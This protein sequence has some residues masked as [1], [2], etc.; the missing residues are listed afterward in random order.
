MENAHPAPEAPAELAHELRRQRHFGNQHQR[1]PSRFASGGRASQID[2]G[3][4]ARGDAVEEQRRESSGARGL[5]HR[6]HRRALLRGERETVRERSG[7]HT[8]LDRGAPAAAPRQSLTT[9][10]E[11]GGQ[12]FA[13]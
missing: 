4:P 11:R 5:V 9:S 12:H 7:E 2:L 1:L 13:P 8:I 6:T 10:R 3:L